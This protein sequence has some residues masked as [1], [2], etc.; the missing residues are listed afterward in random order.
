MLPTPPASSPLVLDEERVFHES[1]NNTPSTPTRA[2]RDTHV[3]FLDSSPS[4]KWDQDDYL[5][6][7]SKKR[8]RLSGNI[9]SS[10]PSSSAR[11]VANG[12]LTPINEHRRS[13]RNEVQGL[14]GFAV[15]E[16]LI[17]S[18]CES[19]TGGPMLASTT[20]RALL[21]GPPGRRRGGIPSLSAY[22]KQCEFWTFHF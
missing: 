19:S 11:L 3:R 1:T 20:R 21:L 22:S 2:S 8:R 14:P 7:P 12:V 4:E 6:T 15:S 9:V 13:I 17:S 5:E 16:T 18:V 10:S